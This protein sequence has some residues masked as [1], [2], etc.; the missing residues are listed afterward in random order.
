[1]QEAL[2][3]FPPAWLIAR[4]AVETC[5]IGGY[6][7]PAGATIYI[8][9]WAMHRDPR[10]FENPEEFLPERWLDGLSQRLPRHVYLPFGGGPRTCIGNRFAMM[11]AMLI[12]ATIAQQFRLS[13]QPDCSVK[14]APLLTLRPAGGVWVRLARR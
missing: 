8:A 6:P 12:L 11:E 14:P 2:R 4:E 5:E 7:V 3:L 10:Y 9:M 1:M 13:W